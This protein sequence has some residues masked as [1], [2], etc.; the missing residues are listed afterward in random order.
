MNDLLSKLSTIKSGDSLEGVL[1]A[2]RL[3][4]IQDLIKAIAAG[5]NIRAGGG[6]RKGASDGEVHLYGDLS[7]QIANDRQPAAAG[8]SNG[9]LVEH[10]ILQTKKLIF[11]DTIELYQFRVFQRQVI[12]FG[13]RQQVT[14]AYCRR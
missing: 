8:Q 14:E 1:T 3:N 5:E 6:V 12:R 13:N 4:A 11:N 2:D 7:S 9:R 10:T